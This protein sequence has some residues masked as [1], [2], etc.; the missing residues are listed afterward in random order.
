[1]SDPQNYMVHVTCPHCGAKLLTAISGFGSELATR[2]KFCSRC[3]N[4]YIVHLIVQT[5]KE[6]YPDVIKDGQISS[7]RDRI[8]YLQAE[9]KKT[10]SELLI[11][12]ELCAAAY[13]ES[14][15]A[16]RQMRDRYDQN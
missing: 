16:A 12:H 10:L 8:K 1:M 7:V 4:P 5:S 2:E 14:L 13:N 15:E 11:K 9:R 3:N 6:L